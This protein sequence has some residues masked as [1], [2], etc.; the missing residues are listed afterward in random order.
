MT[1]RRI[2]LTAALPYANGTL[3]L[4]HLTEYL[5]ADMWVRFQKMR[6]HECHYICGADTHGT[7]IMIEARRQGIPPEKLIEN[8]YAE[9]T[10]EF[11]GFQIEF[12]HFSSTN[13][14][15]NRELCEDIFRK[16]QAK[17]HIAELPVKQLYCEHDKMFLPDRFVKGTCPK[18]SSEDQYGDSC[19]VCGATYAPSEM[20]NPHCS[21]CK[22]KPVEKESKHLFFK[23]EDFRDFLKE[24]LPK[25]TASEVAN[26]M[27]EWF[28]EPLRNWDITRDAPYFGFEIPGYPGKFFYVWVDA[29][30]GYVSSTRQFCAAHGLRFEDFWKADAKTEVYHLIGKDITYFHTLFWPALL[31]T[32]DLRTPTQVWAHGHLL[33]NGKKMSKSKGTLVA[34]KTY[35]KHLDPAYIRYYFATKM[36]STMDDLDLNFDDFVQR[37]NSDLVGKITNLGSRGAQML[38]KRL[39]GRLVPLDNDG[40]KLYAR[41]AAAGEAIAKHYET[42]DYSKAL[43][44]IRTLA[45]E[46][47]KYFDDKAPWKTV[48]AHPD[49]VRPVLS[50]TLNVFRALAIYL[51]PVLPVYAAKVERLFGAS[52]WDW[53]AAT[54]PLTAGTI[55]DFEHLMNRIEPEKIQAIIADSTPADAATAVPPAAKSKAPAT[56]KTAAPKPAPAAAEAPGEIEIDAFT[57]VDLRIAKIVKAEAV[58]EADKLLK[59]QVDLGPLGTRQ[60][61]AGIKSA[62]APEKLEGR[63]TVVVA[64]LKPRKM[65]FGMSEGM[66]LAAGDGGG[67][68]FIMSPDEGAKP[69]DKVK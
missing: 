48:E 38:K 39:D 36:N 14:A 69:G 30:M 24:W 42:R 43:S 52:G 56:E 51:K 41:V 15:E 65:K 60:I 8:K 27:L 64:N 34:L 44:E 67:S 9:H 54:T 46:A 7:P 13:S 26:K 66:V 29:P 17:G 25:H 53:A 55:N 57:K 20:K 63:L 37:V 10:A 49:S 11:A 18:C 16:A 31:K 23:L 45:D 19:D 68:L 59:L 61:F 6:G 47:N 21:V 4:G 33:V 62:Y 3:H 40:A 12:S 58:P 32:G 1:N 35:L 50:T 5:M 2:I 28:N 22:T